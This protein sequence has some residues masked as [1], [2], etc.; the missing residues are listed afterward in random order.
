MLKRKIC[1]FS[2]SLIS[3]FFID[4]SWAAA[5]G[6]STIDLVKLG[7]LGSENAHRLTYS[8]E[9]KASVLSTELGAL[10]LRHSARIISGENS[11]LTLSMAV[12]A[13]N[14][15]I[16]LEI[17]EIHDRR[18]QA[19]GY[20]VAVNGTEV[21]F[22][23]YQEVGAGPNHYF[24]DVPRRLAQDGQLSITLRN[25]GSAPMAIG[26][27]WAY[28]DFDSLSNKDKTWKPMP[29]LGQARVMTGM[30]GTKGKHVAIEGHI[31]T[32]SP[33]QETKAW[34]DLTTTFEQ[35]GVTAPGFMMTSH[36]A[37]DN[38]ATLTQEIRK[39][40]HFAAQN[41]SMWQ[42][43]FMGG[44]WGGHPSRLDGEGGE[45]YDIRYSQTMYDPVRQRYLPTWPNTPGGV[46]WPTAGDAC[47]NRYLVER[48]FLTGQILAKEVGFWAAQGLKPTQICLVG[49]EGPTYYWQ[50]GFGDFSPALM[51]SAAKSGIKLDPSNLTAK[52]RKWLYDNLTLRFN[53]R[54]QAVSAGLGR[55]MIIVD[56]GETILPTSQLADTFYTH[57]FMN[58]SQPLF[59]PRWEGWQNGVND[60]AWISGEPLEYVNPSFADYIASQ[61]MLTN[62]NLYRPIMGK[63]YL[64]KLYQWGFQHISLFD[65]YCG[66]AEVISNELKE[67]DSRIGLPVRH[68]LRTLLS[69][70]PALSASLT[71]Q[72][73]IAKV[74]NLVFSPSL[75][76]TLH[77]VDA[78]R[79]GRLV[80]RLANGGTE[81]PA[82]VELHLDF[83][84]KSHLR[85]IAS[86][87]DIFAG[88][89]P[90]QL[91]LV[92]SMASAN[93]MVTKYWPHKRS[94][95]LPLEAAVQGKK[96]AYVGIELKTTKNSPETG[97]RRLSITQAWKY[98][99]GSLVGIEP[100]NR[101][102][103]IRKLWMQDR[104]LAL[105]LVDRHR[106][107]G[108]ERSTLAAAEDII[109]AGQ[110]QKAYR[111]LSGEH[112]LLLPA[113][114][115]VKQ[116]GQL[117][118]YPISIS[119]SANQTLLVTLK[120]I[121]ARGF[122]LL[123]EPQ[124]AFTGIVNC[125]GL[126]PGGRFSVTSAANHLSIAADPKGPLTADAM[127]MASVV[128][129]FEALP[130]I[131]GNGFLAKATGRVSCRKLVAMCS[132][133]DLFEVQDP[134][135]AR[136]NPLR[137][138]SIE[139]PELERR[140]DLQD[141]SLA[142]AASQLVGS[143]KKSNQQPQ[144]LKKPPQSGDR[145]EIT[146]DDAGRATALRSTYGQAAGVIKAFVPPAV[147][148][149]PC[150]GIIEL[151]DGQKFEF[152]YRYAFGTKFT[153]PG[154]KPW[155]RNNEIDDYITAL[156]PGLSVVL[157]Y[158]PT[159]V[160]GK[161]PRLMSLSSK[162]EA[163][164]K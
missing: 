112:S 65:A 103:R 57:T 68:Y 66:D 76:T 20:T 2:L 81:L 47:L 43:N 31:P 115:A 152:M 93:L 121:D 52:A 49:D 13:G 159:L 28:G 113:K 32:V 45:F 86:Q 38:L 42:Y 116:Q 153:V 5:S 15:P 16:L 134:D 133:K 148:P 106:A 119:S 157:T 61:G 155:A 60:A 120:R 118:P 46:I 82:G 97:L 158:S 21:Y 40:L 101:Q 14:S 59:D 137:I 44:D 149:Q 29:V 132:G 162:P 122:E 10:K 154:L 74:D 96:V 6:G 35:I 67:V 23:T 110:A 71:P 109:A 73:P 144:S 160:Q 64:E 77:L 62:V 34:K 30:V 130:Q 104:A 75:N 1:Y 91:Q 33:E 41:K 8:T 102:L 108:G 146:L 63:G 58:Q 100:N 88:E 9:V 142:N 150:N 54:S 53:E 139:N 85:D 90:D 107:A 12:T 19:I 136:Y 18:P 140:L 55:D 69:Y 84:G 164:S 123:L 127:G 114:F 141:A 147:H 72:D 95:T 17:Q 135:L 99:S 143:D 87:I 129:E 39:S 27:I 79:P 98:K 3:T 22:R 4:I 126:P 80:L 50:G 131:G 37:H 7:D 138:V 151:Q 105:R 25:M 94:A 48:S 78:S 163:V 56:H 51:A 70:D 89:Q 83:G 161:L 11:A 156:K 92:H 24:V 145:V 125:R 117:G 111:L 128:A 26:K 36:Y 124:L